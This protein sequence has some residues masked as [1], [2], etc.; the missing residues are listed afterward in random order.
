MG[1]LHWRVGQVLQGY[2]NW[3]A[4]HGAGVQEQGG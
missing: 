4:L 1:M 2:V 3:Q